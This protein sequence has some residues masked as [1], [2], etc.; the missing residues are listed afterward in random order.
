MR[1]VLVMARIVVRASIT[2][3]PMAITIAAWVIVTATRNG[4]A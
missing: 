2:F 4:K 1:T 3:A